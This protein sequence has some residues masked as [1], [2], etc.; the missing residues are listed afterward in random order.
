MFAGSG[1]LSSS[2]LIGGV[3]VLAIVALFA[4]RRH[5]PDPLIRF[6]GGTL[7]HVN[8][9]LRRAPDTGVPAMRKAINDLSAIKL[10]PRDWLAAFSSAELNWIADLACLI[11][12]C[13]AVGGGG[14]SLL[15]VAIAYLAGKAATTVSLLPGGLGIVD[16][17]MVLSLT[18]GG[19]STLT[20][21]AAVLLYRLISLVLVVALGWL[22]W[23][24]T[25]SGA[26]R[27]RPTAEICESSQIHCPGMPFL[28]YSAGNVAPRCTSA[29]RMRSLAGGS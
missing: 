11:A 27:R 5:H 21:A 8:R 2:A 19:V 3:A 25:R 1:W 4:R 17:A 6:A 10:R 12:C 26:S 29:R 7:A 24:L 22:I 28:P 16:A 9:A 14:P 23:A 18:Q 20:A 13:R 15:L